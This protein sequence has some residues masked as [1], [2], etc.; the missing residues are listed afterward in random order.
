M[1]QKVNIKN[2][3]KR[4]DPVSGPIRVCIQKATL[5]QTQTYFVIRLGVYLT[6]LKKKFVY[7]LNER[8]FSLSSLIK[9]VVPP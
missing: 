6:F 5:R 4:S 1:Q 3:S 7:N 9:R 2:V 8:I